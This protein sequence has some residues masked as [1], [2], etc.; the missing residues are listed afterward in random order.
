MKPQAPLDLPISGMTCAACA[1]RL[2]K[3][4]NKLPGVEAT[5]NFAAEKAHVRFAT[6]ETAARQ[7]I[8]AVRKTGFDVAPQTVELAIEGMTCAACVARIERV[9]NAL[10]GVSA[11]V[12]LATETARVTHTPGLTTIDDLIAAVARAGYRATL[13]AE[14]GRALEQARRAARYRQ[15]LRRFWISAALS[16]PLLLQMVW[17]AA[18]GSHAEP[19]PRWL[20]LVLATPVQFW[21]GWRFYV[22]AYHALRGGGANMDVL[23]ALG[24][25]MAWGYSAA[26]TL[27]GLD[28]QHVYFEAGAVVITLVLL[29]KVLEA[30]AKG[31]TSAAIESLIALT[32]ATAHVERNGAIAPVD[33]ASIVPGD[34]VVVRPGERLPVDGEVIA[35]TSSVDESMFSGEPIPVEKQP[36]SRVYAGTQNQNGMLKLVATGV[37]SHTQLAKIVRL[38]E[39]AQ[40]SKAPIQRLADRIAGIFVPVV[41]T[42]AV[43][44]FAAWWL[45]TGSAAQALIPAVAVLVIACPCAL[46]LATPTAVMVATG[47]GAQLGILPR[48]AAAL[49]NAGRIDVLVLDKTGTLTVGKPVV[50]AVLPAAGVDA[51]LLL[52]V[53]AGL[54]AASEHPLARAV[55]DHAQR[56]GIAPAEVSD[57]AAEPGRGIRAR[58]DG[59]EAWLGAPDFVAARA[60]VEC[61]CQTPGTPVAVALGGRYL[62][63][64]SVDDALRPDAP[65]AV[66]RLRALGLDLVMA[67]GDQPAA[68]EAIARA[69]GITDWRAR[70]SPQ[71]K[72]ALIRALRAAGRRVGMA[73]D[74]IND[75]PA[76]AAADVSFALASGTDIAME[77]AD[78]TL[79]RDELCALP[80]AIELS[81]AALR[82]IRQNLFFAF[83]YNVLGIPLAAVGELNPVIAGAAMALSS[84][85][86]VSN[87]LLLRRWRPTRR[88]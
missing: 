18:T 23:V 81:R 35:G 50:R 36:G 57:F 29:G 65:E 82:K 44:T 88:C 76:L 9:L 48:S 14:A 67:T 86:V 45:I 11:T 84:V 40:G 73:G 33:V 41:V 77:T 38:V 56:A 74:G 30:R 34:V 62:G 66:A 1:A 7:L 78:I 60:G 15:E 87:A 71:D 21:V 64:L 26:V 69:C 10:P 68:A 8:E 17:M 59:A 47:R 28:H 20:Q 63:C 75:A 24:T 22:G 13:R 58:V 54:E 46:G 83:V 31:K 25:S 53:A 37:G 6:S 79:M 5:V 72:E 32:P 80:D 4:L 49:E 2:E 85:S 27:L 39:A 42:I 70:L 51:G 16:A 61:P 52:R 43:L 3:Q 12:N 19:L 55:L